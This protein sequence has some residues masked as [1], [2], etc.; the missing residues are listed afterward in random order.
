MTVHHLVE[1]A[2]QRQRLAQ[3]LGRLCLAHRPTAEDPGKTRVCGAYLRE[4]YYCRTCTQYLSTQEN[5]S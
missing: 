2:A 3:H 1:V 5:T 4:G